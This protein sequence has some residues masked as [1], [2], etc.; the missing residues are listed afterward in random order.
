MGSLKDE[1]AAMFTQVVDGHVR[2][3]E[4]Q[5]ALNGVNLESFRQAVQF[6]GTEQV[7]ARPVGDMSASTEVQR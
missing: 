6:T 2:D 5:Q 4:M 7:A 1:V 3:R